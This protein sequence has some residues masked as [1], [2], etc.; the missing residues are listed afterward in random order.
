MPPAF[1]YVDMPRR[2]Q[3]DDGWRRT[4]TYAPLVGENRRG[5]ELHVLPLLLDM[6]VPLVVGS[7]LLAVPLWLAR[8]TL[9]VRILTPGETPGPVARQRFQFQVKDLLIATLILA[10]AMSPIQII[11][12][13]D[14]A[15]ALYQFRKPFTVTVLSLDLLLTLPSAWAAFRRS[16]Y[17]AALAGYCVI[18]SP[19]RFAVLSSSEGGVPG[20]GTGIDSFWILCFE[21]LVKCAVVYG[22]MRVYY[23]LG[24]RLWHVSPHPFS[25]AHKTPPARNSG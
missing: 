16:W 17:A 4:Y 19:V 20:A 13:M 15:H 10:M 8:L 21:D 2:R 1:G 3:D 6:A 5:F 23:W 18:T 22:V 9:H 7:L 25:A 24:F 11:L 14:D 12:P